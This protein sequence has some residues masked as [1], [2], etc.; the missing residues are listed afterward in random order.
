MNYD[1]ANLINYEFGLIVLIIE[2]L[3]GST[4]KFNGNTEALKFRLVCKKF[5][6]EIDKLAHISVILP[7]SKRKKR[8]NFRLPSGV[9]SISVITKWDS[10][11]IVEQDWK[12][13]FGDEL[14]NLELSVRHLRVGFG[15][16]DY[17]PKFKCLKSISWEIGGNGY[18]EILENIPHKELRI[19]R[20]HWNYSIA[21]FTG[22]KEIEFELRNSRRLI[23][24]YLPPTIQHMT[25]KML[26]YEVVDVLDLSKFKSLKCLKIVVNYDVEQLIEELIL[27][28]SLNELHS[29][30][31][32]EKMNLHQCKNLGV[33][34]LKFK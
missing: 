28:T 24:E 11:K 27:P 22:L 17:F 1:F 33:L 29:E 12:D 20:Y 8:R 25:I 31:K 7:I 3:F 26:E 18:Y 23:N 34:E 6:E 10:Y 32:I 15:S 2:F 30:V 21:H 14:S 19:T 5:K 9:S 13:I 4:I 16:I